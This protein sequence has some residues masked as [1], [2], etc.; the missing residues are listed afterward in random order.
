MLVR[1]SISECCGGAA[2]RLQIQL[3]LVVGALVVHIAFSR[4]SCITFCWHSSDPNLQCSI[5][6]PH[7]GDGRGHYLMLVASV[8][9]V[10]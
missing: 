1:S 9:G 2:E 4:R 8:R 6:S 3:R 5:A 7:G 10:L